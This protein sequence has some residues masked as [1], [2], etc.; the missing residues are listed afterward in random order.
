[1]KTA[2]C[3]WC[4][5]VGISIATSLIVQSFYG[6][7]YSV[8]ID[9]NDALIFDIQRYSLHDGPGIRTV[10]FF[11]GCTLQCKWC[12][13][14]ESQLFNTE[15]EFIE[16]LCINCNIC[17]KECKSNAINTNYNKSYEKYRINKLDCTNCGACAR[18]CPSGALKIIGKSVKKEDV[19]REIMKDVKY[20]LK[21]GGGI[22]L[23]GGEPLAQ[24]DFCAEL[25]KECYNKNIHTAVETAGSVPEWNVDKVKDYVDLFLYD[26]KCIDPN[27]HKNLTGKTN[28]LILSNIRRLRNYGKEVVIRV[29]L[30]PQNN[31]FIDEIKGILELADNLGIKEVNIMPYHNLGHIK[32]QRLCKKYELKNLKSLKFA[33][34]FEEQMGKLNYLFSLYKNINIVIGG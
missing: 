11:K 24:P 22:T 16:E 1:M 9:S 18:V 17:I 10:I 34:D 30:I 6:R 25:L 28:S 33:D 7:R 5:N 20:Y 8:T 2:Y 15:V 13:N 3:T 26:I 23:S 21:S 27:L 32:Y 19:M 4:M 14:P 29:P 31:F 12:C